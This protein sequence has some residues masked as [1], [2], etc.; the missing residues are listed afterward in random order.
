MKKKPKLMLLERE[1]IFGWLH[2][3]KSFREIGELLGRS[4]TSI[5]R[6]V[7]RNCNQNSGEYLPC[8]A[9]AKADKRERLQREKAPLKDPEIFLYVKRRLRMG[10][11]PETI[12]GTLPLTHPGKTICVETIYRYIY[13]PLKHPKEKLFNYLVLHRKKRMKRHGRKVHSSKIQGRIGIEE[14]SKEAALRQEF[15]HGETDL[16]EGVRSDKP[17]LHVTIERKTR[18]TQL[19]LLQ[20][21]TA[22]AKTTAIH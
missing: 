17:V 21:K 18:Y 13:T 6:E 8:V 1:R 5:A 20:N 12:A 11:S 2:E 15:G 22:K 10:W 14:R 7:N 4:H 9:Q 19:Q 16:M 3:S